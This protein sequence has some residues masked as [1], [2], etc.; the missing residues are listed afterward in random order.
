MLDAISHTHTS[1]C[2]PSNTHTRTHAREHAHTYTGGVH[3]DEVIEVGS[4]AAGGR[5]DG[6]VGMFDP[7]G[8]RVSSADLS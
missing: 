1:S 2:T 3:K 5:Y 8:K 7:K 6:L 4:V